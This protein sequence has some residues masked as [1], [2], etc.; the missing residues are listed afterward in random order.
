MDDFEDTPKYKFYKGL[1]NT[2]KAGI[3]KG[4]GSTIPL[5]ED[6]DKHLKEVYVKQLKEL[7]EK[8]KQFPSPEYVGYDDLEVG[9]TYHIVS[10]LNHPTFQV[11]E[12]NITEKDIY[13]YVYTIVKLSSDKPDTPESY[14]T[15]KHKTGNFKQFFARYKEGVPVAVNDV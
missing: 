7:E 4:V 8:T 14:Y 13:E 6:Y 3:E 10:G 1:C 5:N 9:K 2:F 12:K 11:H 15:T